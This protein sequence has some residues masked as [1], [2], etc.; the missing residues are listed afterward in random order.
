MAT[1]SQFSIAVHIMTIL[2]FHRSEEICSGDIAISVNTNASFVRRVLAR[3]SKAGLV[4]ASKGKGGHCSLAKPSKK[5][6]LFDIYKAVEA[7]KAFSIHNYPT[8]KGCDISCS[9][10]PTLERILDKT[11]RSLEASLKKESLAKVILDM[12]LR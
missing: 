10:K 9:I 12:N 5:I 6:S 11:Q 3:L 1:N 7:P 2:A 8:Q 4:N